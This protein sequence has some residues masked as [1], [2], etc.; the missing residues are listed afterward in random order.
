MSQSLRNPLTRTIIWRPIA[1]APKD[2]RTIEVAWLVEGH[3]EHGPKRTRW[4]LGQW[5]GGWT[6]SHWRPID[7]HIYNT[8]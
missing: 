8:R 7:K 3:R 1:T 6:P 4:I 2:G 5:E